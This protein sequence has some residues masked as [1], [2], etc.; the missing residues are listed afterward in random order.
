[1]CA[2]LYVLENTGELFGNCLESLWRSKLKSRIPLSPPLKK[3]EVQKHLASSF[4]KL[5]G[6]GWIRFSILNNRRKPQPQNILLRSL[7]MLIFPNQSIHF[8]LQRFS[9]FVIKKN[10]VSPSTQRSGVTVI[11]L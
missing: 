2:S 3:W 1:M 6:W 9:I 8:V 4:L 11:K 5:R 7:L 10:C